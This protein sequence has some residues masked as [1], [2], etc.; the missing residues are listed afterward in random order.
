[1]VGRRLIAAWH[2]Q[3]RDGHRSQI[4]RSRLRFSHSHDDNRDVTHARN[5]E[6]SD[7]PQPVD[8][9]EPPDSRSPGKA[10]RLLGALRWLVVAI[11]WV[12]FL[13]ALVLGL[14]SFADIFTGDE[15][16]GALDGFQFV[17]ALYTAVFRFLVAA[18]VLWL[19]VRLA[20]WKPSRTA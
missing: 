15:A 16:Y 20:R 5:L 6:M 1:M 10:L 19:L 12:T 13:G 4:G 11:L 2:Q 18:V 9:R 14:A 17:S 8:G 7:R 3:V